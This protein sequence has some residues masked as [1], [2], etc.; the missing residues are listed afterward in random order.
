MRFLKL[1]LENWRN[2]THLDVVLQQRVFLVG[3]NATGKSNLLD[4]FRFLRDVVRVGGGFEKA[5]ADR[6]GVSSL[7]SVASQGS[8]DIVIDVQLGDD[9][10]NTV[11][12]YR[13]A[14][15]QDS[16]GYPILK[17]EK[18][19]NSGLLLLERPD[20][21]DM[22][23]R[24][25]LRQTNLEQSNANREFRD[26]AKFLDTIRYY[27]IVPQ[28]VREPER[29]VGHKSD[30]YGGDFLEQ[31]MR[32]PPS[33]RKA[34]L[35]RIQNVLR[36]AVPQLRDIQLSI[37]STHGHGTPHLVGVFSSKSREVRQTEADF[38]DGTLRLIGLTWALLDEGGPL[39][40]EEP[41]VYLHPSIVRHLPAMI[42]TIQQE[43]ARQILMSTHSEDLLRD[44]GIAPDE[45]LILRPT[46][47]GTIVE[48]V[49]EIDV[50]KLLLDAG[51]SIAEAALPATQAPDA[52]KLSFLG[53]GL[54]Q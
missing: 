51:L 26:I 14:F 45:V 44:E 43:H 2:F 15:A 54:G 7:R 22:A 34:R 39:L 18:V 5:V 3:A 23:D 37:D 20:K 24:E 31:V 4:V 33:T 32:L 9:Q 46:V 6:G 52:A 25:L 17:E 49:A 53:G 10:T 29:S 8:P 35:L 21:Q 36:A 30:P 40:W 50:V 42:A 16:Q 47:D 41:E 38:S 19:W 28:L 27:H 11:W 1:Q 12:Q 48:S 13:L